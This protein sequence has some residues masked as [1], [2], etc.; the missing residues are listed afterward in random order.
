VNPPEM[1]QP[2]EPGG[3]ARPRS[4]TAGS[5]AQR[6]DSR[7]IPPDS[8][9]LDELIAFASRTGDRK[10]MNLV[11]RHE[12]GHPS[13]PV[14]WNEC[15]RVVVL[16][17]AH[18]TKTKEKSGKPEKSITQAH[19]GDDGRWHLGLPNPDPA[20]SGVGRPLYRLAQCIAAREAGRRLLLVLE[21][22]AS[23]DAAWRI[24]V[25]ATCGLGGSGAVRLSD[26]LPLADTSLLIGVSGSEDA[27]GRKYEA[28]VAAALRELGASPRVLR[29]PGLRADSGDDLVEYVAAQVEAG[30]SAVEA[31]AGISDLVETAAEWMPPELSSTKVKKGKKTPSLAELAIDKCALFHDAEGIGYAQLLVDKHQETWPVRCR[32]FRSVLGQLAFEAGTSGNKHAIDEAVETISAHATFGG[33]PVREAHRRWAWH[34]GRLYYDLAD[35][36][37]QVVEAAADVNGSASLRVISAAECPIAFV[38]STGAKAQVLPVDGGSILD[39]RSLL[40]LAD[41]SWTVV[42][43]FLVTVFMQTGEL[44]V[45]EVSGEENSGKTFLCELVLDVTDPSVAGLCA[46]PREVR[47]L[48]VRARMRRVVGIDNVSTIT[49]EHSDAMCRISTGTGAEE[50]AYYTNDELVTYAVRATILLNGIG[51]PVTRS[52]LSSRTVRVET[53][54]IPRDGQFSREELLDHWNSMKPRVLGALLKAAATAHARRDLVQLQERPRLVDAAR[55]IEAAA[56]ALELAPGAWTRAVLRQCDQSAQEHVED[57]PIGRA[58][59]ELAEIEGRWSGSMKDL[60]RLLVERVPLDLRGDYWPKLPRGLTSAIQRLA[61]PLRDLGV[62]IEALPW[63]DHRKPRQYVIRFDK[64]AEQPSG[65]SGP[66]GPSESS[67]PPDKYPEVG[68][69]PDTPPRSADPPGHSA[70]PPGDGAGG[71]SGASF[72]EVVAAEDEVAFDPSDESEDAA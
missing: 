71:A 57:S 6:N 70:D 26:W 41:E 67:T 51:R 54:T 23:V 72:R 1:E 34:E 52:D 59:R 37:W 45:L 61:R 20:K 36:G 18:P 5:D 58:V 7:P 66:S 62:S 40:N 55:W 49:A 42:S 64:A 15:G 63:N 3:R 9:S 28:T 47:D 14:P 46:P 13:Y 60:L 31:A 69:A 22:E 50:R 27:T 56:P 11:A 30:R 12:Y 10:G 44:P 68:G 39:L 2:R 25:P 38:R 48:Y 65:P 4:G 19:R 33:T 16:R 17:F 53:L 35:A 24:G 43:G 21:G 32:A 29:L 8:E